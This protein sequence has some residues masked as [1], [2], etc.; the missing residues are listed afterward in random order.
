MKKYLLAFFLYL[1]VRWLVTQLILKVTMFAMVQRL[2]K[3]HL[4]NVTW[5]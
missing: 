5:I 1:L 3:N 2:I 4:L